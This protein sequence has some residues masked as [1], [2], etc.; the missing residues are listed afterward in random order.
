MHTLSVDV[1]GLLALVTKETLKVA[2]NL[3]LYLF[4]A[5]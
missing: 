2:H 4:G 5:S 3:N 1:V